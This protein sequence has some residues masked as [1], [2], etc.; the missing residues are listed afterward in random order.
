MSKLL[1]WISHAFGMK[2]KLGRETLLWD[3]DDEEGDGEETPRLVGR[4]VSKHG[5]TMVKRKAR[6]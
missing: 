6:R 2:R 4:P 3:D 5:F 1:L